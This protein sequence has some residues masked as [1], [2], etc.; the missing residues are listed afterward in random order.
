M[1][2]NRKF[3]LGVLMVS[4][5]FA[6]TSVGNWP[7]RP[8]DL[9]NAVSESGL[10]EAEAWFA[11]AG[12]ASWDAPGAGMDLD[13]TAPLLEA[14]I[15]ISGDEAAEPRAVIHTPFP[16]PPLRATVLDD[17]AA[18]PNPDFL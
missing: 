7:H 4:S 9:S 2:I 16:R 11:D 1:F 13:P 18:G 3:I 8:A 5:N 15:T 10:S 17:M 14:S 6:T 12:V